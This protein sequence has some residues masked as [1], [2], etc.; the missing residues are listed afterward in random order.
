MIVFEQ[1]YGVGS[2]RS[3]P[4]D[5]WA[6]RFWAKG[7]IDLIY[8]DFLVKSKTN[9]SINNTAKR[10]FYFTIATSKKLIACK[11]VCMLTKKN[12]KHLSCINNSDKCMNN[13][14]EEYLINSQLLT[15]RFLNFQKY[16]L[17][18]INNSFLKND[19]F[20]FITLKYY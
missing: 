20:V 19:W 13:N 5:F 12:L 10:I 6:V 1:G 18:G 16:G 9:F 7:W 2:G 11:I 14:F 4:C 8:N 3:A 17:F 15:Y